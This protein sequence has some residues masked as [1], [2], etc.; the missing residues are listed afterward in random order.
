MNMSYSAL[1]EINDEKKK[2]DFAFNLRNKFTHSA[3]TMG[4]PNAGFFSKAYE[5]LERDGVP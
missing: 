5:F 3:L 1:G 2:L 4:S